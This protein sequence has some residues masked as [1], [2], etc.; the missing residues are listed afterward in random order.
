MVDD[1]SP[2]KSGEICDEYAK[3]DKR[4]VVIHK[5]NQGVALARID[6]YNTASGA[7]VFFLDSDDYLSYDAF[8]VLMKAQQEHDSEVVVSDICEVRGNNKRIRNLPRQYYN[9]Q[10][11]REHLKSSFLYDPRKRMAGI[12]LFLCGKLFKKVVLK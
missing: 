11:I 9:C 6:G 5:D 10:A 4:I 8:E 3:K 7:F 2:D 1:G 12:P